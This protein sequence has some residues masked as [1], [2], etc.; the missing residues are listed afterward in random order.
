MFTVYHIVIYDDV[1]YL[2]QTLKHNL[3]SNVLHTA[4]FCD[5]FKLFVQLHESIVQDYL[6]ILNF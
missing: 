3:H 1:R 6:E 4:T 2:K 5:K